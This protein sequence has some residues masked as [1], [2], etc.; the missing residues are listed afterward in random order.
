M[1]RKILWYLTCAIVPLSIGTSVA[2]ADEYPE[3]PSTVAY[4]AGYLNVWGDVIGSILATSDTDPV[5]DEIHAICRRICADLPPGRSVGSI[6]DVGINPPDYARQVGNPEGYHNQ[7]WRVCRRV[8]NWGTGTRK[9]FAFRVVYAPT[10]TLA[11]DCLLGLGL[12]PDGKESRGDLFCAGIATTLFGSGSISIG[13]L[14]ESQG[15]VSKLTAVRTD[16]ISRSEIIEPGG[17]TEIDANDQIPKSADPQVSTKTHKIR[18]R[19]QVAIPGS[20]WMECDSDSGACPIQTATWDKRT[21]GRGT[22][23]NGS[24]GWLT[25]RI[26][27]EF[28]ELS[29]Q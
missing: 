5:C 24:K 10:D 9:T 15:R 11:K 1:F 3:V 8:K 17:S 6:S 18:T 14:E 28:T 13:D 19:Y 4:N 23:K 2:K 27:M 25:G 12:K 26:I 16:A 7:V 22:L 20:G 29:L 21:D